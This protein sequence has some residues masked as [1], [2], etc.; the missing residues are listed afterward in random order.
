M[1]VLSIATLCLLAC[2][3]FEVNSA[4]AAHWKVGVAKTNITP[5]RLMWMSGYGSR[6]APA[7]GKRTDLWG[8]ALALEDAD[9]NRA[10]LVTTDL[11]GIDRELSQRI[12][13]ALER[14]FQLPRA[15]VALTVSH[16]HTGPVVSRNLAPMYD[17]NDEQQRHVVEYADRLVQQLVAVV[18]QAL[19]DLQPAR[20]SYEAGFSSMAVNRRN[21][22]EKEVPA[23]RLDG[24]LVGPVD[25]RVPVLAVRDLDNKLRAVVFGYACHATVLNDQLW[26]GDWPGYAQME[27]ERR[28]P[29]AIAMFWAGCGGDQNP[30][31][32]RRV[33]LA[34]QYGRQLADAVETAL[35]GPMRP[36]SPHLRTQYEEIALPL[37]AVPSRDELKRLAERDKGF[38]GATGKR[39]LPV[40]SCEW[41]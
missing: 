12:C 40:A 35:E 39:S 6:T 8:K 29:E 37:D 9:G 21:N 34:E 18:G 15:A 28:H 41:T 27:I 5:T 1:R 30:L 36:L 16:T 20:V 17:L 25:H 26:S 10:V 32:R 13:Q 23:R 7:Q 3:A 11:V 31:P 22:P 33:E 4:D 24:D 38:G 14:R 19:D 2:L